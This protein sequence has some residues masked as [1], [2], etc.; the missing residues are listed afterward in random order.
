VKIPLEDSFADI[1]GKAQRG[2]GLGDSDLAELTGVPTSE[3]AA[4]KTGSFEDAP[5]R[6]L[7]QALKLDPDAVSVSGRKAW[8][9]QD[10]GS[11]D[12]L[13]C[14]NTAYEDM[15]VNSYLVWDPKSSHAVC[16]DTGADATGMIETVSSKGLKVQLILLTHTHPD[17]IA[18]LD[19]LKNLTKA[20]SFVSRSEAFAG[21]QSFDPGK[22]FTVGNLQIETRPTFGHSRGGVTYYVKGLSRHIAIVGDAM[23]AGSMGGGGVSYADAL[24]TNSENILTLPDDTILCPGHG[25]LTTVGEEKL[26]NPFFPLLRSK[27]P[28][29]NPIS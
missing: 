10:P 11:V 2:L 23:F 8:Y 9:P 13:A 24:R 19:R 22:K 7:A 21:A 29:D 12:G 15:T 25:P 27:D 3:I 14:F 4:L 18:D 6:K 28:E 1:L 5:A 26:H 20:A 16:F 17:H